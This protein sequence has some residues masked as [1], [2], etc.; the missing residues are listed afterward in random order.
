MWTLGSVR[1]EPGRSEGI[2]Y[3]WTFGGIF[4]IHIID[5]IVYVKMRKNHRNISLEAREMFAEKT[6]RESPLSFFFELNC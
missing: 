5:V 4:D 1:S 2:G 6:P 3:W